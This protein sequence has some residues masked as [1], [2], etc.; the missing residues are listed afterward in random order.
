MKQETEILEA[1]FQRISGKK[2]RS[3]AEPKHMDIIAIALFKVKRG[4]RGENER[5]REIEDRV[6]SDLR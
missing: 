4:G 6:T 5:Q 1:I 3:F 2:A